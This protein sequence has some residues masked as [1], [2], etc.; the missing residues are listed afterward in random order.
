MTTISISTEELKALTIAAFTNAGFTKADA[1][2]VA[3]ILV[4]TDLM[5]ISTHGVHRIEQYLNRVR[6]GVVPAQPDIKV[7]DKAPSLAVVDGGGGQGQVVGARAL[8]SALTKAIKTGIGFVSVGNSNHF[9]AMAPYG[10]AATVAGVILISG[11]TASPSM[12]PFGGRDRLLGNNPIG[13]AAP[14]KGGAP[15]I[16][17]MAMSIAARG[18]MRKHRD[19]NEPMPL[20]WALDADGNPTTDAQA[21]LDGFIQFIGGHKGYG[22][23][24]AVDILSGVLSGGRFLN[25]VGDMWTEEEPQG[26]SHF[27]LALNL[28][29]LIDRQVYDQRMDAFCNKVKASAPFDADGEVLLPGELE[30]RNMEI[31]RLDGIPLSVS[32]L[33]TIKKL[34]GA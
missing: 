6:A 3:E 29:P 5:G 31:R 30:A 28:A 11:T 27:F 4:T 9:G 19:A 13:F 25:D 1:D 24:F 34:A 18:K 33:D 26:V 10:F 14:R 32:L 22:L 15:F 23:A 21:G 12:T 8:E 2:T 16:L 20:G 7:I 17:D